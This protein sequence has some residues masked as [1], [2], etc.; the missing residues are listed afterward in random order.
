MNDEEIDR[1]RHVVNA[2]NSDKNA[3]VL[4]H[5]PNGSLRQ[6]FCVPTQRRD[7]DKTGVLDWVGL[8]LGGGHIDLSEVEIDSFMIATPLFPRFE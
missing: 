5:D 1:L 6:V 3:K 8:L 7:P 4:W 2:C